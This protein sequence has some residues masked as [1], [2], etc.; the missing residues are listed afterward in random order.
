MITREKPKAPEPPAK[1]EA[2]QKDEMKD[3]Y[4]D[5]RSG[6]TRSRK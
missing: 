4:M 1:E 6:D 3:F 5:T 2:E